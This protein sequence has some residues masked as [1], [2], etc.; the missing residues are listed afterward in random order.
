MKRALIYS[1]FP[2]LSAGIFTA[3]VASAHGVN[4]GLK[5]TPEAI[6]AR[7]AK[8]ALLL[9]VGVDEVKTAWAEG[10]SLFDVATAHGITKED[11]AKKMKA[12]RI[13]EAKTKLQALVTQGVITQ[14][15]ADKRIAFMEAQAAKPKHA[16]KD[17][18]NEGRGWGMGGSKGKGFGRGGRHG[19]A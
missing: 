15:Q 12:V 2:L 4:A 1:F 14:A 13:Q 11:L 17:N 8:E 7:F 18:D 10:K 9:G 19:E 6:S 5:G 3:G 16:K